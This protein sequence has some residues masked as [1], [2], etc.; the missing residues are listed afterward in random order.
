MAAAVDPSWLAVSHLHIDG[1]DIVDDPEIALPARTLATLATEGEIG[2]AAAEHFSVMGYQERD[3]EGWRQLEYGAE[4]ASRITHR[5]HTED[6]VAVWAMSGFGVEDRRIDDYM[7]RA[8]HFPWLVLDLR[9]NAGGALEGVDR[10]LGYFVDTSF[11][12]F[13]QQYRDS[14]RAHT[15]TP[16]GD[17][18]G[19]YRGHVIVLLDSEWASSS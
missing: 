2:S 7:T 11:V 13:T 8:R 18:A 19:P 12:A 5:W 9:G 15:V 1:A 16:R 10:L 17:G 3:L 4:Q 6:S 14:T